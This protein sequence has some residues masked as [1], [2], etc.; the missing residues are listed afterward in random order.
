[1]FII[2]GLLFTTYSFYKI[3]EE[4]VLPNATT[5]IYIIIY[6][7]FIIVYSYELYSNGTIKDKARK[8]FHIAYEN[9]IKD[10]TFEVY[11]FNKHIDINDNKRQELGN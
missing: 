6:M 10:Y 8:Y 4:C 9:D 3:I 5:L 11:N 7:I 2:V 1:M